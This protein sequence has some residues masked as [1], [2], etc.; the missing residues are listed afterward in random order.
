MVLLSLSV[1][2]LRFGDSFFLGIDVSELK[3]KESEAGFLKKIKWPD[4]L[5]NLELIGE[6]SWGLT[7]CTINT[8]FWDLR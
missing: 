4:K 2:G 1:N 5:R 7:K 3:G 8:L 6:A